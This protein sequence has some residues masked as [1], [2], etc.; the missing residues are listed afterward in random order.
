MCGAHSVSTELLSTDVLSG[1]PVLLSQ[2]V[3]LCGV[4]ALPHAQE[5]MRKRAHNL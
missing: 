5:R 1:G 2:I 4:S 3:M